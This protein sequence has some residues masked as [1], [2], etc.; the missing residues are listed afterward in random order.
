MGFHTPTFVHRSAD[1]LRQWADPTAEF[2]GDEFIINA[3]DLVS[4]LGQ[5]NGHGG[6]V[7]T[8]CGLT[9]LIE[10][11]GFGAGTTM[12]FDHYGATYDSSGH[13]VA[14]HHLQYYHVV[15]PTNSANSG[16]LLVNMPAYTT[17]FGFG[18]LGVDHG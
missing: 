18:T 11:D 4:S 9:G 7:N 1:N 5:G 8:V 12:Y 3:G 15:D 13:L 6:Q 17:P 2:L 14:D 10:F 16:Y